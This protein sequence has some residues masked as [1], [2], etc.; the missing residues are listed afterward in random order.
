MEKTHFEKLTVAQMLTGLSS[1]RLSFDSRAIIFQAVLRKLQ[2]LGTC[3]DKP[4][5][6]SDSLTN[7]RPGK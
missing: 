2:S 3:K 4:A 1:R 5:S 6:F 7:S